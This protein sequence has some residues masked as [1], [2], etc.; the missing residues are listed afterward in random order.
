MDIPFEALVNQV[1][2]DVFTAE[3]LQVLEA[4]RQGGLDRRRE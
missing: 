4:Y 2:N 3:K 1:S